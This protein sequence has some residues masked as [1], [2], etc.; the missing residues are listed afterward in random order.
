MC[1]MAEHELEVSDIISSPLQT[2]IFKPSRVVQTG[3]VVGI[4]VHNTFYRGG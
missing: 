2:P 3:R 1:A 4:Y